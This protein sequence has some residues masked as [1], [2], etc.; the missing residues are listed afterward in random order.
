M[1]RVYPVPGELAQSALI[2]PANYESMYRE[3]VEDPGNF[4]RREGQRVQWI[5]PFS[6]VK[7]TSFEEHDFRIQWF[8]DGMLN[9]SANCLDR[10]LAARGGQTAIIWEGDDPGESRHISYGELLAE[11]NDTGSLGDTSTIAD[12]SV[13]DRLLP[14]RGSRVGP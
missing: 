5:H 6:V 4:W 10:H 9:V 12:P 8:A 11:E 1:E 7:D 13:V 14:E 2:K 3:S